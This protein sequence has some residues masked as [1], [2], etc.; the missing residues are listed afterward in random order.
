M[1]PQS[2]WLPRLRQIR[3]PVS[4]ELLMLISPVLRL[5]P[6]SRTVSSWDSWSIF[7]RKR[8]FVE[9]VDDRRMWIRGFSLMQNYPENGVD[10]KWHFL[11]YLRP[12]RQK[13]APW[14]LFQ[15]NQQNRF[16]WG[17]RR[18]PNGKVHPGFPLLVSN[19][20]PRL[21]LCVTDLVNLVKTCFLIWS[22]K[23]W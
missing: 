12:D 18:S 4:W 3:P 1:S 6:I 13:S 20:L 15:E 14:L 17:S 5:L 23:G 8:S 22:S 7:A 2:Q 9:I 10:V 19:C 16:F 11:I 21:R